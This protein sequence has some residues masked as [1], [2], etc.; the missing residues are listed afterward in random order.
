MREWAGQ[1][2]LSRKQ[3]K[4]KHVS[5]LEFSQRYSTNWEVFIR[6]KQL[7]SGSEERESTA[8][9]SLAAYKFNKS[10]EDCKTRLHQHVLRE[11]GCC[12]GTLS[13]KGEL[14]AAANG[15][16]RRHL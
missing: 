4:N 9:F 7:N 6:K 3:P 5:A 1:Q 12:S 10:R 16:G 13:V 11:V 15:K 2:I 8:V 14:S